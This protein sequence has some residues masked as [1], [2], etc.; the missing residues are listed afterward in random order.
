MTNTSR[1][2]EVHTPEKGM[3]APCSFP[4]TLPYT[5]LPFDSFFDVS[6]TFF[7]SKRKRRKKEKDWEQKCIT[8]I[9]LYILMKFEVVVK[10]Y[11]W[12]KV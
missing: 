3:E 9:A 6:F 2:W 5:S 8:Q 1:F 4:H 12:K 11:P 7:L 10:K